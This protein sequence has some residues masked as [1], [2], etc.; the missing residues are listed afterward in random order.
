MALEFTTEVVNE[1]DGEV[2]LKLGNNGIFAVMSELTGRGDRFI[3]KTDLNAS[4][5]EYKLVGT[6]T[7]SST[8]SGR[9]SFVISSDDCVENERI[10]IK[11]DR[12]VEG[13]LRLDKIKRGMSLTEIVNDTDHA[14]QINLNGKEV[15][16]LNARDEYLIQRDP[17]STSGPQQYSLV[18]GKEPAIL[19]PTEDLVNNQRLTVSGKDNLAIAKKIPRGIYLTELFN[20]TETDLK[21][22]KS[23]ASESSGALEIVTLKENGSQSFTIEYD[24]SIE[25]EYWV[26]LVAEPLKEQLVI[27]PEYF[28]KGKR[29]DIKIDRKCSA[30]VN[31]ESAEPRP[32][33]KPTSK[34]GFLAM[35]K[36][37]LGF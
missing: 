27:P 9:N 21:V 23:G 20:K 31:F 2:V 18:A 36:E 26:Q 11:K 35:I 1:S 13:T 32:E 10:V 30:G 34:P 37:V 12:A 29:I 17:K 4:Y 25:N 28:V 16:V 5:Q 19:I 24:P 8:S 3:I 33:M 14:F 7:S 15:K 22:L 6:S